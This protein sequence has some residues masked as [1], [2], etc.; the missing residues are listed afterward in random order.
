MK[1]C[2]TDVVR[3]RVSDKE[4]TLFSEA[5][6]LRDIS[7]S[8]WIRESLSYQAKI[9]IADAHMTDKSVRDKINA[10]HQTLDLESPE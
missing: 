2:L 10:S 9:D 6:R 5:A 3:M 4:K 1:E 7:L 8:A